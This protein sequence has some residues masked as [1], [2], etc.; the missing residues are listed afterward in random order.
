MTH[1]EPAGGGFLAG[2]PAPGPLPAG[3]GVVID[4]GTRQVD[5]DTL[6]GG[7]PARMLRLSRTGRAALA[8]LRAGP[9]RSDAAGWLANA[10]APGK[11]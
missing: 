2:G 9:V 7:A 1:V 4:P 5:E 3:F 11:S 6:F 10:W 8:E